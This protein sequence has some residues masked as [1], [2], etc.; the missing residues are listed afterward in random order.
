MSFVSRMTFTSF[1]IRSA[2][3]YNHR[4]HNT[5]LFILN[6]N[7]LLVN[8]R[9][10]LLGQ[11]GPSQGIPHERDWQSFRG[12]AQPPKGTSLGLRPILR[13]RSASSPT[14]VGTIWPKPNRTRK[15]C[16]SRPRHRFHCNSNY[17][18]FII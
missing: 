2:E 10:G 14:L 12:Y 15:P 11:R 1:S 3:V 9:S 5:L 18:H 17:I 6:I 8:R 13:C 4:F 7:D 16:P